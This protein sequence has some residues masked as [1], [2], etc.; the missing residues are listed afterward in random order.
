MKLDLG[1][2]MVFD[3][4]M[5]DLKIDLIFSPI[6][7][8]QYRELSINNFTIVKKIFILMRKYFDVTIIG[9]HNGKC[10]MVGNDHILT[11]LKDAI[12]KGVRHET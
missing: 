2:L 5:V 4:S 1:E 3:S 8:F 11:N 7:C 12:R 6:F 10:F 9:T